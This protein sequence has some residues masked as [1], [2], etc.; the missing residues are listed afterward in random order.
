MCPCRSCDWYTL[1]ATCHRQSGGRR[2]VDDHEQ[3]QQVGP[4]RT[5]AHSARPTGGHAALLE[6]WHLRVAAENAVPALAEGRGT[7]RRGASGD[8]GPHRAQGTRAVQGAPGRQ[9]AE[10]IQG[11][12]GVQ[13]A[14]GAQGAENQGSLSPPASPPSP[15][16]R[17]RPLLRCR[18]RREAGLRADLVGVRCGRPDPARAAGGAVVADATGERRAQALAAYGGA[19]AHVAQPGEGGVVGDDPGVA[20]LFAGRAATSRSRGV[21]GW[22]RVPSRRPVTLRAA[23]GTAWRLLGRSWAAPRPPRA[24][25]GPRSPQGPVPAPAATG[26]PRVR[27]CGAPRRR[28]SACRRAG[29]AD[30]S[31]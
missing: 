9:G 14:R 29:P 23:R 17:R 13:G 1:G 21:R 24:S 3:G 10:G 28:W 2:A 15:L 7:P 5:R 20:G 22:L 18:E 31:R 19:D 11:T 6:L 16:A 25:P 4:A 12:A 27:P 30:R 8:G 26:A